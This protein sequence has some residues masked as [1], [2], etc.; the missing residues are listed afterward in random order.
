MSRI[1]IVFVLF[2]AG[3][4]ASGCRKEPETIIKTITVTDTLVVTQTDTVLLTVTD[5]VS[6]TSFIHDTATTFILS[7]H[8]ETTGIGSDPDLSADGAARAQEL[9]RVLKNVPLSAVY[10]TN[11]KRTI[12]T[13]TPT[14]TDKVLTVNTYNPNAL[15]AFADNVLATHHGKTVL[16]VGHSNTTPSLL[17]VLTGTTNYQQLPETEFDN[18]YI[19]TVFEKGRATVTHLKYGN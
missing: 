19:V 9:L 18:L 2:I 16:V 4:S 12:Q 11:Y 5:T 10:S 13:A 15:S 7:R 8:C 14:A 17:N 6:L 1:F 3:Y